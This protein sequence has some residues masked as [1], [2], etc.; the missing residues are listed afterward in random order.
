[1][2]KLTTREK[3][4]LWL[5]FAV[6]V[7]VGSV[8]LVIEPY[9]DNRT[10]LT[11]QINELTQEELQ[12]IQY[13]DLYDSLDDSIADVKISIEEKTAPYFGT[14]R[15]TIFIGIMEE[16]FQEAD[17]SPSAVEVKELSA[18]TVEMPESDR[19]GPIEL[20]DIVAQ[21]KEAADNAGMPV[22]SDEN[23]VYTAVYKVNFVSS[24]DKILDLI[25]EIETFGRMIMIGDCTL[26]SVEK[27][28]DRGKYGCNFL[29]TAQDQHSAGRCAAG[30]T[31]GGYERKDRSVQR[32]N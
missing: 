24:Y 8:K 10:K 20:D 14:I 12:A 13:M 32:V 15:S 19:V 5:L 21:M 26:T 29:H 25:N 31:A 28:P 17:V 27:W 1:M 16:L 2:K 6:L 7:I 30:N 18:G 3:M 4:L 22:Q 11:S 23:G 9:N